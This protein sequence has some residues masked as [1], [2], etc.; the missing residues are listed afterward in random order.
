MS[1]RKYQQTKR[2]VNRFQLKII[3]DFLQFASKQPLRFRIRLAWAVIRGKHNK[4]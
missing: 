3:S 2:W 4:K 1:E